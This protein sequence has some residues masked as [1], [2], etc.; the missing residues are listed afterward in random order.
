MSERLFYSKILLAKL[1][2]RR[3]VA[4][5]LTE[6][7]EPV[8][9]TAWTTARAQWPD[10]K[11]SV[12]EFISYLAERLAD[13]DTEE[14]LISKINLTDLY[15]ACACWRLD[16]LAIS[17]CERDFFKSIDHRLQRLK[18]DVDQIN[19][20]KQ[21]LRQKLF[22]PLS[23]RQP[24]ICEYAGRGS[25]ANFI[26][27]VAIREAISFLRRQK[28]TLPMEED[29]LGRGPNIEPNPELEY[30]K[31]HYQAEFKLAFREA[32]ATLSP[33]QRNLLRQHVL[34]DLN[35]DEL[36]ALYGVHRVTAARWLTKAREQLS[37]SLKQ[38]LIEQLQI[39]PSQ[40]GS[41]F[42]LVRSE[43]NLSLKQFFFEEPH[44]QRSRLK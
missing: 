12:E 38:I 20:V 1:Q 40:L 36:G 25:L 44:S 35:I 23:G 16:E 27:V 43:L 10:V 6:S 2:E 14:S 11:L 37:R 8:L 28:N 4:L 5:S 7:I 39:A 9:Q 24:K 34:D 26:Q 30:M 18:L 22:F 29:M 33:R 21:R 17:V 15:L 31:Q 32:I 19:E 3:G 41:I 42:N 13:N